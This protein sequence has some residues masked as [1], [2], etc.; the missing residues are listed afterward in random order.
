M[1]IF[2][3]LWTI[4]HL[5][6][7]DYYKKLTLQDQPYLQLKVAKKLVCFCDVKKVQGSWRF[8]DNRTN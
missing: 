7:T 3:F 6:E 5:D 8:F 2:R 1:G 4:E